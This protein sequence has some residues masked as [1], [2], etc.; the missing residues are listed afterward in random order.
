MQ[1][2]LANAT[3]V[4]LDFDGP[5]CSIFAGLPAP[6]VAAALRDYISPL[7]IALPRHIE[8]E[9]DPLELLRYAA[10]AGPMVAETVEAGLRGLELQAAL[11]ATPTPH[12]DAAIHQFH[13]SGCQLAV[14][15]NNSD[16]AIRLYL[17]QRGLSD[18]FATVSARTLFQDPAL[19][20]PH[21]HLITEAI[22]RLDA[23]PSRC[24]LIGDSV[25]DIQAA[26]KAGVP[27]IGYANRPDKEYLLA[28]AGAHAIID[29]MAQLIP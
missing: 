21:S 25:T 7:G 13:T 5:I 10:S 14:V 1:R 9:T 24:I 20:K 22:K 16:A 3:H 28:E 8:Y 23:D 18:Y 19:L 11:R 27:S 6:K 15:S 2:L 4:L 17:D 29:D 12:A 26:I